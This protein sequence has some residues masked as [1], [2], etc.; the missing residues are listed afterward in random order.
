MTDTID[1]LVVWL[2]TQH[3]LQYGYKNDVLVE[4][5]ENNRDPEIRERLNRCHICEQWSPCDVRKAAD[6][7][8]RLRRWQAEQI[9][10][11]N[12]WEQTFQA[13]GRPGAIGRS[14]AQCVRDH[15]EQMQRTIVRLAHAH[16]IERAAL[17]T[18]PQATSQEG[19]RSMKRTIWKYII[20]GEPV[21]ICDP[22]VRYIGHDP[23]TGDPAVW[24]EHAFEE[25]ANTALVFGILG[26][27]HP[28]PEGGEYAGS[29]FDLPYVWHVYFMRTAL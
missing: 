23:R 16:R 27:G 28:I 7:I 29:F 18:S 26:T 25:P 10:V 12:D 11:S 13:L 24:I 15:V 21:R 4:H 8:E 22:I 3:P 2:R 1:D 6:E 9:A 14:K 19:G 5:T 17:Q 20:N